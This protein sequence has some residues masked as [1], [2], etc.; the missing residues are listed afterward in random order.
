MSLFGG[1]AGVSCE[2]LL[3]PAPRLFKVVS[4]KAEKIL[5]IDASGYRVSDWKLMDRRRSELQRSMPTV[6]LTT[7]ESFDGAMRTAPNLT[8]WLGGDVF[9][10][11]DERSRGR[12][13]ERIRNE[14]LN[15]LRQWSG[16]SDHQVLELARA[17]ALP[18]EPEYAEW[19]VLLG[20]GDLLDG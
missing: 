11:A 14:R 3:G 1:A 7:R 18:L 5:L 10:H 20:R 16:R 17:G 12:D 19:L 15:A 9:C 8:S 2:V 4:E 13:A 6:F